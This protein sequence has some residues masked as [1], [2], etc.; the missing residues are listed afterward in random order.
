[1]LIELIYE[2]KNVLKSPIY[3]V[4]FFFMIS[5]WRLMCLIASQNYIL[6][7]LNSTNVG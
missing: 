6:F 1:M 3:D 4:I 5:K 7:F 2:T